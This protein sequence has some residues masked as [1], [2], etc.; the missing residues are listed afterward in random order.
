MPCLTRAFDPEVGPLVNLGIAKPGTLTSATKNSAVEIRTYIALV[1]TGADVTCISRQIADDV[2]LVLRGKIDMASALTV[3]PANY[4]LADI[5]LPF[6]DP[7]SGAAIQTLISKSI[8]VL[9]FQSNSTDY[10]VLLGRDI[11]SKGLFIMS[12]YDK[13]FT[14]CM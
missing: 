4:Y 7:G 6:G 5:A 13:R 9:E 10:Q 14:I 8:E 2:G 12:S 1:D 3:E 11:I